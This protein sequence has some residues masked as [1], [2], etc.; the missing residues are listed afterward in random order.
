MTL[1]PD[2]SYYSGMSHEEYPLADRVPS[3]ALASEGGAEVSDGSRRRFWGG[4]H[5]LGLA[6]AKSLAG[7]RRSRWK[8]FARP[9]EALRIAA[10]CSK[11]CQM[12]KEFYRQRAAHRPIVSSGEDHSCA[13]EYRIPGSGPESDENRCC[14]GHHRDR[15]VAR[16]SSWPRGAARESL[17]AR[18]SSRLPS[19]G[20]GGWDVPSCTPTDD[21]SKPP[22]PSGGSWAISSRYVFRFS[23]H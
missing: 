19:S 23:A 8:P 5:S 9:P 20:D 3:V 14:R 17:E 18:R 10:A 2:G 22:S 7:D 1:K 21:A 12:S 11:G 4:H 6:R 13:V 15:L 16:E